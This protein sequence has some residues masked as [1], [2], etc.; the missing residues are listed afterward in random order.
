[1]KKD[2]DNEPKTPL[3][4]AIDKATGYKPGD[5][6][7][8]V[9]DAGQDGQETVETKP[10]ADETKPA[11]VKENAA[12][13]K[14]KRDWV[15]EAYECFI[16]NAVDSD[17]TDPVR[18]IAAYFEKNATDE[19]KAKAKAEGK[20]AEGCWKFI[21]AMARKA[22][23]GRSGHIDPVAV[24]AIAMHYFQDVPKDWDKVEVKAK[25]KAKE[26]SKRETKKIEELERKI[27]QPRSPAHALELKAKLKAEK[28]RIKEKEKKAKAKKRGGE[29]GFFFDLMETE[30]VGPDEGNGGVADTAQD[31]KEAG[32]AE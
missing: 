32:D 18:A 23:G 22:L 24:Y 29:Q 21:E 13:E 14:E 4:A 19:L 10:S 25:S 8:V 5:E 17:P 9:A 2:E 31:G 28:E 30:T 11:E 27:A 16:K 20:T 3:E 26:K 12:Q 6:S 15:K 7:R 1:M